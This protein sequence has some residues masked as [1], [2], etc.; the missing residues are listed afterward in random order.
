M[1]DNRVW[2]TASRLGVSVRCVLGNGT[3]DVRDGLKSQGY[4]YDGGLPGVPNPD[5]DRTWSKEITV[6]TAEQADELNAS[7]DKATTEA[8]T[9]D[10]LREAVRIVDTIIADCPVHVVETTEHR[11]RIREA[12]R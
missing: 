1:S 3:Y 9:L 5:T 12:I 4:R 2:I 6:M 11:D 10:A 7:G 8:A